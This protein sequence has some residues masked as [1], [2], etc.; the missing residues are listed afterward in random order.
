MNRREAMTEEDALLDT[1]LAPL[2]Q[3][4]GAGVALRYEPVYQQIQDARRHDDASLPMGDWDRPLLRADWRLAATLCQ[5]ALAMQGKDLQ[6]AAWLCEAWTRLNGLEGLVAG[7]RLLDG[8]VQRYW[9]SAWPRIEDDDGA[10]AR[11]A[12]FLW[13]DATVSLACT[14]HLPLLRLEDREPPEI[15]LYDWE[16]ASITRPAI[17]DSEAGAESETVEPRPSRDELAPHAALPA[18]RAGLKSLLA[19]AGVAEA[20]WSGLERGL[21]ERL[22]RDAPSLRRTPEALSRLA[23]VAG[24][25]LAERSL[26]PGRADDAADGEARIAAAPE[27][28]P[29]TRVGDEAVAMHDP[30]DAG[31]AAMLGS[32][33][34]RAQAYRQLA[35]IADYLAAIEPHSPTPY[36]VR[37]AVAWGSMSLADLMH[38]VAQE[39]GGIARYLSLLNE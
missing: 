34:N 14:L 26:A 6:V 19:L 30:A 38:E 39:E 13:L 8:L 3:E 24:G 31:V 28:R 27:A 21:D 36:L 22:G 10:D 9:E 11:C 16:R 37:K 12:P 4:G 2:P 18:N 35:R 5:E 7:I 20:E 23:R 1:L 32:P 15:N 33:S 17:P 29:W 25:L